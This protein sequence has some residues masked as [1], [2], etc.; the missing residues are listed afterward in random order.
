MTTAVEVTVLH[1]DAC[2]HTEPLIELVRIVAGQLKVAIS[3]NKIRINSNK[4]ARAYRSL[5]SPTL[6]IAGVDVEPAAR[7]RSDYSFG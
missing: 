5:G 3:L 2:A 6:H 7:K 1:G 4:Q